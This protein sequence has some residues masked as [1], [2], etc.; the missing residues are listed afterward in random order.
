MRLT[1]EQIGA[2]LHALR[3]SPSERFAAELDSRVAEGFPRSAGEPEARSW[4]DR[5]APLLRPRF[6]LAGATTLLL[7]LVVSVAVVGS[8][9]DDVQQSSLD[10]GGD[11]GEVSAPD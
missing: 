10:S 6:A 8:L 2:E 1:D 9:E 5:V 11:A 7:A 3:E 4:R